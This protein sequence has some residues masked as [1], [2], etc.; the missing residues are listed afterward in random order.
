GFEPGREGPPSGA[1]LFRLGGM[2]RDPDL[3][4]TDDGP[5]SRRV[6]DVY[7]SAEDGL[8]ESRAVFLTGCGLPG[9]GAGRSRFAVGELGFGTGLNILALVDAWRRTRPEGARLGVFTVEA[10]PLS[11]EAAAR[12]LAA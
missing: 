3:D 11:R 1:A 5:R 8:G 2:S 10:Y 4:W 7:F 6:G 12:A 9:A